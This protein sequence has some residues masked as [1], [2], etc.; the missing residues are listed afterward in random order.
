MDDVND[1]DADILGRLR[2]MDDGEDIQNLQNLLGGNATNLDNLDRD[3]IHAMLQS[4]YYEEDE[5][6]DDDD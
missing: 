1:D 2:G 3:Q 5:F 6:E 4:G